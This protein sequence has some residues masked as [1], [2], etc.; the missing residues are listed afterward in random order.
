MKITDKEIIEQMQHDVD[1]IHERFS[2]P[3]ALSMAFP[4]SGYL[5]SS[6]QLSK[7][8]ITSEHKNIKMKLIENANDF[9]TTKPCQN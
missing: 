7:E 5:V 1:N 3:C 8:E 6:S 4:D 2:M 9:L